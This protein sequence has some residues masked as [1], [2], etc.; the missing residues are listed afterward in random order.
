[1]LRN[2]LNILG[3]LT[4]IRIIVFRRVWDHIIFNKNTS[5]PGFLSKDNRIFSET[6]N[7]VLS[8]KSVFMLMADFADPEIEIQMILVRFLW[9]V[10][11]WKCIRTIWLFPHPKPRRPACQ[12]CWRTAARFQHREL[13]FDEI[14]TISQKRWKVEEFYKSVKSNAAF[15]KSL[16][17]TVRTQ[18]NHCFAAIYAF[19]KLP[20]FHRLLQHLL[21]EKAPR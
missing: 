2:A 21:S 6:K 3:S 17:S 4:K 20:A 10:P 7:V 19:I 16:A 11:F 5:N 13:S 18:G 9:F 8:R 12:K 15:T 14:A 1:M